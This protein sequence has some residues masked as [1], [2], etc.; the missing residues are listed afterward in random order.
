MMMSGRW[1]F[2]SEQH[3]DPMLRQRSTETATAVMP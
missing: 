3:I 2:I 1:L